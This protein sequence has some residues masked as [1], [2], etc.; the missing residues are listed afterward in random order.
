MIVRRCLTPT[1]VFIVLTL[2][3]GFGGCTAERW[4]RQT[5]NSE[6]IPL[7]N[8][9]SAQ[10]SLSKA[11][12]GLLSSS[13]HLPNPIQTLALPPALQHQY[14]EQLLQLQKTQES[15]QKLLLL[16]Q[17]LK[18]QQQLLQTQ[19][20]L[21][22]DYSSA[23]AEKQALPQSS[24]GNL[25]TAPELVPN[26]LVPPH[27][28]SGALPPV[29]PSQNFLSQRPGQTYQNQE[30]SN[31]PVQGQVVLQQ[32]VEDTQEGPHAYVAKTNEGKRWK[33]QSSPGLPQSSLIGNDEGEVQL[34][35]V[36]AETLAQR[37]Q[38]KRN[39]GRKQYPIRQQ[40]QQRDQGN[41]DQTSL[42]PD[43]ETFARQ[44]LQQIQKEHE[45]KAQFLKDERVKEFVR[46][47][48]EQ[49]AL[50]RKT[51]LQQ[52]ALQR[53]QE[54]LRQKEADKKR[55]ELERLEE[56]ARQ[57]ELDRIRDAREKQR[58]EELER[59]RL[60]EL[61]VKE[62]RRREEEARQREERQKLE[63]EQQRILESQQEDQLRTN[64]PNFQNAQS[65]ALIRDQGRRQHLTDPA[66]IKKLR[67]R[68]RPRVNQY[69]E[70]SNYREVTTTPSPNQPPLSVYMGS[71]TSKPVDNVKVTDVLRLLRN[72]KTIAVLDNVGPNSP[73]VFV[74]PSNL[75][76]PYGYVKFDLPY[77]SSIDHNRV[78]RKVDKLPFFVAPLS[79]DPPPG[80]SKIP[81]PAPHIGSVV[82]NNLSE[83]STEPN[84]QTDE[85]NPNPTPVIQPNS[86]SDVDHS[87]SIATTASY[88]SSTDQN[89]SPESS[90]LK[91]DPTYSP[92]SSSK[93]RFRQYYDNKPTSVGS[94]SYYGEQST[95]KTKPKHYHEQE[96]KFTTQPPKIETTASYRQEVSYSNTPSF[97]DRSVSP[98]DTSA[99]EQDLAAQLALI[100]QELVQQ[101]EPQK[102]NTAE[103]YHS[104]SNLGESYDDANDVR[105]PVGPTQYNLPAELPPISPHLPGLVNSLLDKQE[106]NLPV[107]PTPPP[108]TTTTTTPTTTT[109]RINSTTYRP[110]GRGRN[111]PTRPRTT[112]APANRTERTRR[113]THNRAK[114]RF[115][116]TTEEY[117]ESSY[118]PTKAKT[119][120][121]T[122]KYN[123]VEQRRPASRTQKHRNRDRANQSAVQSQGAN[124][125]NYP[126]SDAS[127]D[128]YSPPSGPASGPENYPTTPMQTENYPSALRE[129]Q[130]STPIVSDDYARNQNYP[131][132][133]PQ[134]A[135]YQHQDVMYDQNGDYQQAGLEKTPVN[136]FNYQVA[137]ENSPD[138]TI[139]QR[140]KEYPHY[141]ED[142]NLATTVESRR[143]TPG[144]EHRYS[145][146]YEVNVAQT[147]PDYNV[148][149]QNSFRNDDGKIESA[150]I[151]TDPNASPIFVP[152][153]QSKQQ[154]YDMQI[155][156]TEPS[157]IEIATTSTTTP[158]PVIIRQRVRARLGGGRTHHDSA[159]QTRPRNS[160]DEYV[161]FSAVN[162]DSGRGAGQRLRT[163]TRARPQSHGSQVQTEGNEYIKIHANQQQRLV[164]TTIPPTTT[165]TTARTVEEDVD[166]GFIRPPNF[167]PAH[168]AH[169]VHPVD[170]RYQ[171]PI[172]Y[173]P[174]LSEIQHIFS[175][176]ETAV[177][178]S[179]A[180]IL[181]NRPKYQTSSRRPT[182]KLFTTTTTSTSTETVPVATTMPDDAVYTTKSKTRLDDPKSTRTRGRVR[183]PGKK[184]TTTTTESGLEAN[185]EL[186]LDEN[187][188]RITPQQ[189]PV[190]ASGQQPL[191]DDNFDVAPQFVPNQNRPAQFYEENSEN[192][193]PQEFVLNFGNLP[194]QLSQ[195]E[196][197]DQTQ[198]ASIP[199]KYSHSSRVNS[200]A[201]AHSTGDI[202]GA[203]SQW[204][205]KL[206]KT[207]FQPSFAE[208]RVPG[209]SK[210]GRGG[211]GN[212][213]ENENTPEIITAGPEESSVTMVVSSDYQKHANDADNTGTVID[214][215]GWKT[216][217]QD[218]REELNA[219]TAVTNSSTTV[220]QDQTRNDKEMLPGSRDW[221]SSKNFTEQIGNDTRVTKPDSLP[222]RKTR[223]RKVRV[224]V[225]PLV[226]DFVTA[227]SQHYNS[228]VNSLVQ[229]QYK[230]NP[231]HDSRFT[232]AQPIATTVT[233]S[234][235]MAAESTK[236][237]LLQDFLEE[238]LKNDEVSIPTRVTPITTELPDRTILTP[239]TTPMT[240]PYVFSNNGE[241]TTLKEN[242]TPIDTTLIPKINEERV[243]TINENSNGSKDE[244]QEATT[245][246]QEETE[247]R[248]EVKPEENM[249]SQEDKQNNLENVV[250]KQRYNLPHY[251]D[252]S[253]KN[254]DE[255]SITK[256]IDFPKEETRKMSA[257]GKEKEHIMRLKKQE[258]VEENEAH[259]KNHRVK[260]SEVKYPSFDKSQTASN[261]Y[262]TTTIPGIVTRDEGNG[263]VKTLT[264]YVKAIF[265]SMKNAEEGEKEEA[266][267]IAAKSETDNYNL[268]DTASAHAKENE[269]IDRK[270][271][272]TGSSQDI[273][274]TQRVEVEENATKAEE[275]Q[276]ATTKENATTLE[277]TTPIPDTT[278]NTVLSEETLVTEPSTTT[279]KTIR[280]TNNVLRTN[281]T[282]LGKV[283]R[284]STTT[285]VSHMT[286]ICYRGRCVMTRP[287]M[288]DIMKR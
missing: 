183:R 277:S 37:G 217:A 15:I 60:S 32:N 182:T 288:E 65:Q 122:Q 260:W 226:D 26:T 54:L 257:I 159:I 265:D 87:G 166:Y 18:A 242:Y 20:F 225:R 280:Q 162:N 189:L 158:A 152:L 167:Q 10:L 144:E 38:L 250:F 126:Q 97:Q 278:T 100:N 163:R 222:G 252:R 259:P 91:Y 62:D 246:S 256:L 90:S 160:Q 48:E 67:G 181:K 146:I 7:A 41:I 95:T 179:P 1:A 236:K 223:R 239:M 85:Q 6:W 218:H 21:P 112:Q 14:Q 169:P 210:R 155:P 231:I 173:R 270:A 211:T 253:G 171:A 123:A 195:R 150:A 276:E 248:K 42:S 149:G 39:R 111:V 71:P 214:G 279:T 194:E 80:Y 215:F 29:H 25:Q 251:P 228:A 119:P 108:T 115:T 151:E 53:E 285:K 154:D 286:E 161:R 283:L 55:K 245:L 64:S 192:Y 219:T 72:A 147:Q 12:S 44:V 237:S 22:G 141:Q 35:Y 190:T 105:G 247:V 145:P 93:F 103:Q 212:D 127:P 106:R 45:E 168:P 66:R 240:T 187:Y 125:E 143:V 140:P 243:T 156:S 3:D 262:S 8:P 49:K 36:P 136:G 130:H 110:R 99:K 174:A 61:R 131:Q 198:L 16:Q 27:P 200:D 264:D 261:S 208:N 117:R 74:G 199:K 78:E 254:K 70:Q 134:E 188:P 274:T 185:N 272:T 84:T 206:S 9:G 86:Y 268:N 287:K 75:D 79:F 164:A 83:A 175:N 170:N 92:P 5:S 28:S 249:N 82:V 197:Y 207:S 47:N 96:T 63:L 229:D 113:P 216:T 98:H 121:T 56:M 221:T 209:E 148:G 220:L 184:R 43:Q 81:F 58:Q 89:F 94:T 202:Y 116:T 133:R 255:G 34:V 244:S 275:T 176:D 11:E 266:K 31:L 271:G 204:S 193:P 114:S 235:A 24:L 177:E 23:E 281:S 258:N 46:L 102:Y 76:P 263:N 138:Q 68:Q 73:Q 51:R 52:E 50:E 17:Q 57:R 165:S 178:S 4:S 205:T 19:T 69:Q 2:L 153:Q 107:A 128:A 180:H 241:V 157:L 132:N 33:E 30:L 40:H 172:T 273:S 234:T 124:Y 59:R 137:N 224:R 213:Q 269:K 118:E 230:Y 109:T 13:T 135:R 191:Y 196:E 267:V 129:V 284:T 233:A 201:S 282:M 186:P 77:L 104:Q 238:M 203:E 232:T 88:D 142:Y 120:E 139:S 101:R 227:E